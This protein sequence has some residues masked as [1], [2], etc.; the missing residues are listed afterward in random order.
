MNT[1]QA[2]L[3]DLDGTLLDTADDLGEALNYVLTKRGF[4]TMSPSQYRPVAS[5]GA[6]G[7]LELGF[8]NALSNYNFEELRAE[9]LHYYEA[10]IANKTALYAGIDELLTHLNEKN[11][12][13][14]IVTNKPELLSKKLLPCFHQFSQSKVLVGGDTLTKRKPDPE[15]LFFAADKLQ[16]APEHCLYVGDAPRDIEAGNKANMT[17][18]IAAWGYIPD[19]NDCQ[20][21]QADY[22]V[23]KPT[24][25]IA[26]I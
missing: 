25:I 21:W 17:T 8:S 16:V 12:V 6:K 22:L 19:I 10:N 24:D 5:D 1:P 18:I 11:I 15:P 3:F 4:S 7:L 23:E 14:G 20:H 26:L 2:V 13:W 9:F